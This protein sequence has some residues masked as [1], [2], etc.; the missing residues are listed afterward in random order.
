M[1]S[2]DL[3][4]P[5]S[6]PDHDVDTLRQADVVAWSPSRVAVPVL[7]PQRLACNQRRIDAARD[8]GVEV[9]HVLA[10]ARLLETKLGSD[11]H[12]GSHQGRLDAQEPSS[13][14]R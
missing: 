2:M 14:R 4:P 11:L 10:V 13:K 8:P 12:R 6:R 1:A 7:H 9:E 3:E 5:V